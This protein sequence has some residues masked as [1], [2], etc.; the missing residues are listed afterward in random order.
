MIYIPTVFQP[1]ALTKELVITQSLSVLAGVIL[2]FRFGRPFD[3]ER[4]LLLIVMLVFW[5]APHASPYRLSWY[6]AEALLLPMVVLL[7]SA[8]RLWQIILL[9]VWTPLAWLMAVQF[10]RGILV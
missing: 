2:V 1:T 3:A 4:R 9:G 6:R 10:F 7:A 5:I 8:P